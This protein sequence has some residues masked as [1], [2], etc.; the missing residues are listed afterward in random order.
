MRSVQS[1]KHSSK[2]VFNRQLKLL[3]KDRAA[4]NKETQM[5]QLAYDLPLINMTKRLEGIRKKFKN[6]AFIGPNPYL[7]L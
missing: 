3:H 1:L 5:Y 6:I 7:F 4:V 2:Q